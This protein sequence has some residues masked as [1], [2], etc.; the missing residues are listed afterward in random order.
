MTKA[1]RSLAKKYHPDLPPGDK[2]AETR[3]SEINAAYE[4]IKSGN[5]LSEI[6]QWAI[7]ITSKAQN[8]GSIIH[9]RK[10]IY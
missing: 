3:M 5:V 8:G 1:Y 2:S 4:A 6:S 9:V 7:I 10:K